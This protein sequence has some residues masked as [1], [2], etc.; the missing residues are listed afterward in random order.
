MH[1]IFLIGFKNTNTYHGETHIYNNLLTAKH[2]KNLSLQA[3][4]N[5][6]EFDMAHYMSKKLFLHQFRSSRKT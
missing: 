4:C 5:L 3:V 6:D 2:L 1:Y